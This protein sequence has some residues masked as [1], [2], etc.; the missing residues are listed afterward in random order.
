MCVSTLDVVIFMSMLLLADCLDG[1]GVW[2]RGS[3]PTQ[4]YSGDL[5][6]D[7]QS[8]IC[9]VLDG[10]FKGISSLIGICI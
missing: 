6:S 5:R 2:I 7:L 4:L 9:F 8:E 3:L 1:I 10:R